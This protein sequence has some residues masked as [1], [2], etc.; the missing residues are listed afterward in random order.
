MLIPAARQS[1]SKV[2]VLEA[3]KQEF[4]AA[5]DPEHFAVFRTDRPKGAESSAVF[6]DALTDW[7]EFC[8]IFVN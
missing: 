5:D 1:L 7:I 4:G 2:A 6:D 3:M 8:A